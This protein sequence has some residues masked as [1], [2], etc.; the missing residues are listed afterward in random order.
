MP[1]GT[2]LDDAYQD[3]N[4]DRA[5]SETDMTKPAIAFDSHVAIIGAPDIWRRIRLGA[6]RTLW[7]LHEAIYKAYDRVDDRMF[8]FYLTQ[9]GSRGRSALRDA[10]EYA[11]PYIVEDAPEL[12][13]NP[14]LDATGAM[15]GEIGI[16]PRRKFHYLWDFGDE[17]WQT[18]KVE[19]V[20]TTAPPGPNQIVQEKHGESPDEFKQWPPGRR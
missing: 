6:D 2:V 4:A 20:F 16:T 11:D 14:P 12:G 19:Q 9:P 7:N 15:L 18:V 13:A 10:T 5:T 17:W 8:C 1:F 3:V